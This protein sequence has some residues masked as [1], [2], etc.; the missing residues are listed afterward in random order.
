MWCGC[1]EGGCEK[2]EQIAQCEKWAI[3]EKKNKKKKHKNKN[4]KEYLIA[5][6]SSTKL[7]P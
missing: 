3:G 2:K 4:E 1:F 6:I 7:A 5:N